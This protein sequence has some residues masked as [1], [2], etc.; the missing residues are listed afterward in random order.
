MRMKSL[1]VAC[2]L[3]LTGSFGMMAQEGTAV[4]AHRGYWKA[5]GST[6]N[7]L[8]ALVKAD[9]I[10]C[11]GSEFDVWLTADDELVVNH[12]VTFKGVTMEQAT[13]RVCTAVELSNGENL[14]TLEQYLQIGKQVKTKLVLELKVYKLSEERQ[15]LAVQ[16][17]VDM[18]KK[19]GLEERM[20]YIAFSLFATKEFVRLAPKGTPVYYLNGD[21][22]PAELKEIGCAGAD[23][24]YHV[25]KKNPTW[26]KECQQLGLKVNV[27]TVNDKENMEWL[28]GE[29]V[30][31]ITTN[32]PE[33][34]QQ[35]LKK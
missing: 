6:Q 19:M 31:F 33:L 23:Y 24:N 26:I 4:I 20:E 34:L 13:K 12:D 25:F 27:W 29:G 15:T 16:K 22:T 17:V 35:L 30:D 8:A 18:V 5:E 11:Y 28:I 9:A 1:F 14:P 3:M 7:S 10:G 21:L 2:V 32:E